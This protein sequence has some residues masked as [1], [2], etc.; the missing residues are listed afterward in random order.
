MMFKKLETPTNKLGFVVFCLSLGLCVFAFL[1]T[2]R[3]YYHYDGYWLAHLVFDQSYQWQ[4]TTFKFGLAGAA[5]GA[6]LAW[7]YLELVKRVYH[8]VWKN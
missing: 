5:I 1:V 4:Q 2:Y 7:N 3:T 8:W 6:T